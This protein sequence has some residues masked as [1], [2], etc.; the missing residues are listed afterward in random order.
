MDYKFLNKI[1]SPEDVKKLNTDQLEELCVEIRDCLISTVSQNG[2]HLAS[3]LG[4]VELTV[5]LHRA[6]DFLSDRLI[7]DVGHQC[8]THKLLTGRFEKFH[9]IRKENGI[10][11]FMR[12]DESPYDPFIT[13]HSS[14]SVSAAL[15]I[16][17]AASVSGSEQPYV[18]SVVGD[19]AMTGGM[20][21]E[22]LNNAGVGKNSSMIVILN[23]NKISI[24]R[25][26]GA[27]ARYL[28]IIRSRPGYHRFKHSVEKIISRIPFCGKWINSNLLRSKTMLKNA[29]YHSNIFEDMGFHYLGPV[30]GHDLKKLEQILNIAKEQK[31]PVLIHALTVKGKGYHFAENSPKNYHGVSAFDIENG[32]TQTSKADF[33]ACVGDELCR[34]AKNDNKLCVITAAMTEGT[35]LKG[36]AEKYKNRFFDV[37]I[38]E[39]H[40]VTFTSGLAAG[41]MHP[42]FAVYSTF[43][44]RGYDQIIHDAA[45]AGLPITLCVDRAGFVGD[46]GETHQ[47]IFDVAFLK[48]IPGMQI[49]APSC[50]LELKIMLSKSIYEINGPSAVRYPRG[51][52]P[53]LPEDFVPTD[54]DFSCYGDCTADTVI[55]TFGRVFASAAE[56]YKRLKEQGKAVAVI[57]LNKVY[58]LTEDF[59]K[60][61]MLYKNVLIFEEGIATGG[62]NETILAGLSLNGFKGYAKVFAVNDEFVSQASVENQLKKYRLDADSMYDIIMNL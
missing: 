40:A 32:I 46:D 34:L 50:Y 42:V 59:Y 9:T 1:S 60:S 38:A 45:I 2:G 48:T 10:S 49:F 20:I 61:L 30:D 47:G 54:E 36:F 28:N 24:S 12:P 16:Y 52:Q 51:V 44:Q 43:L 3:N 11:G 37:G 57:K 35:G 22:G 25:N 21:F 8:Y 15:G 26:V 31:R 4:V 19:G 41:G 14:N 29:I 27:F 17:K 13:G 7:F 33:S 18:I 56:V 23:D 55:V 39:E 6:F 58:P 62:I 5:A 53:S